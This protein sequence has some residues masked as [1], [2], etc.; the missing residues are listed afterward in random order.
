MTQRVRVLSMAIGLL[1]LAGLLLTRAVLSPPP[2]APLPVYG[3]VPAF[4]LTDQ[5]GHAFTREA[6]AGRVWI[7]DFIFTS[8]AGQCLLMSD[9]MTGL[10]RTFHDE[11]GIRFVSFSVDPER[12]TPET[13]LAYAQRH[14]SDARWH[15]VT[16]DRAAITALCREGFHLAFA[17]GASPREPIAHSVR[18]VLVDRAGQIRGYYDAAETGAMAHLRE[19]TRRLLATGQ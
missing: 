9:Q 15:F 19:D 5:Q 8:C 10:Q 6:L 17:A 3:M 1:L 7:A 2:S 13:L 18:L 16:G 4:A 12:D 14:G 11:N